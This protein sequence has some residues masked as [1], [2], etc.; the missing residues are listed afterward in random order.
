M[1]G[2]NPRKPFPSPHSWKN[3]LL[4]ATWS[5]VWLLLFRPTPKI[6]NGWRR[7]LLR[8]FGAHIGRGAIVHPSVKIWA[9]WN[10]SMDDHS[11]LAPYVD[12]YSAAPIT[13]GEYAAVS[14]Y[15]FLCA[16][17]HDYT[18]LARPLVVAP[19][20]IGKHAWICADVFVGPGVS[21]GEG[22][23]V[24]ARSSVYRSVESWW[25]VAG[26]PARKLRRRVVIES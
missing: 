23:V 21:I 26:N 6:L 24:G 2:V 13:L 18:S 15:S 4:R 11:C 22:A 25:V 12:C 10:L 1:S 14:Q 3:R 19:I 17:T 7:L 5:G 16:A 9:P 8:L 20:T